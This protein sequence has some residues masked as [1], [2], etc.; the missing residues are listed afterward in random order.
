MKDRILKIISNENLTS[1]A[2]ADYIGVQRS[3]ISHIISG[4]NKPS[5]DFLQKIL[6]SFPKYSAEWLIMDIGI[7]YKENK[8]PSFF[9]NKNVEF[10]AKTR[11]KE[12]LTDKGSEAFIKESNL[13]T[14]SANNLIPNT[15][16]KDKSSA[17][18]EPI[19]EELISKS[20][21]KDEKG[22]I[23]R[24]IIFYEDKTFTEY[25]PK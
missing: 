4:R 21:D 14:S 13:F 25:S 11:D 1:S 17:T 23:E 8:Q 5:L 20:L 10:D 2:F 24:I 16:A 15:P 19:K 22:R 3:S 6:S 9:A 7:H 18:I 12:T